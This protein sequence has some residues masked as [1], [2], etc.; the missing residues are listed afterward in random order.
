MPVITYFD[1]SAVVPLLVD[2]AGTAT[3]ADLWDHADRLVSVALV[4]VE[5]RAA[6]ARANRLGR[7]SALQLHTAKAE[8]E[9]LLDQ[10]DLVVVDEDLIAAAG[11]VAEVRTLR[12]YDALHL[13]A[14]RRADDEDLVLVSGDGALLDAAAALGMATASVG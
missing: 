5:A 1:T 11:D 4:R 8:L 2:E 7:I 14:A 13:A 10:V 6:L 9:A 12:A 3:A